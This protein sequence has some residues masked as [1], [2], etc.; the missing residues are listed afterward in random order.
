MKKIKTEEK[1]KKDG[2]RNVNRAID[3]RTSTQVFINL[4]IAMVIMAYFCI[5]GVV[6]KQ[7][8][9]DG[10]VT[11][12]KIS[13]LVFL[14]IALVLI[15]RAYKKKSKKI[16]LYA[17]EIL[18]LAIHSL[19]TMYIIKIYDFD[20]NKYVLIS[21]Y[22][23]SI[24][25]VLKCI[26]I[27]TKA[28]RDY[29][30]D[31]SDISDIVQKD[32]PSVKEASKKEK[33]NKKNKEQEN[34]ENSIQNIEEKSKLEELFDDDGEETEIEDFEIDDDDE[35]ITEIDDLIDENE[36]ED[37]KEEAKLANEYE[38]ENAT[39]RIEDDEEFRFKVNIQ[40]EELIQEDKK[41]IETNINEDELEKRVNAGKKAQRSKATIA[42]IREKINQM[43]EQNKELI[44]DKDI[45][46][47]HKDNI[48]S[49]E[50]V[51]TKKTTKTSSKKAANKKTTTKKTTASKK[52]T[53]TAKKTTNKKKTEKL[54]DELDKSANNEITN[55]KAKTAK[56]K[57]V[58]IKVNGEEIDYII[59]TG[60]NAT[61]KVET[62]K[63]R[64]RGRPK[65]EVK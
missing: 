63:P 50:I 34:V 42:S 26:V 49:E 8:Y 56:E 52:T 55:S 35:D 65:K 48:D 38:Q 7:V 16:I 51:E 59:D 15:E 27:N 23:F 5:I 32:Q 19:T 10:I 14:L 33:K 17:F 6:Y 22:V 4:I 9:L 11:A 21:S 39:D 31:M 36:I 29:L 20:F 53:T 2:R 58:S 54:N 37:S 47:Q 57:P 30:K 24:Y 40:D 64:K 44:A 62:P 45:E 28:R 12:V 61:E 41:V 3:R 43:K 46:E 60:D 25:Y 18:A 1:K 13:T